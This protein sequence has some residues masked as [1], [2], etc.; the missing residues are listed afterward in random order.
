MYIQANKETCDEIGKVLL[1]Q[2]D[3][4]KCVRVFIAGMA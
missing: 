3:A 1:D 2:G 4:P